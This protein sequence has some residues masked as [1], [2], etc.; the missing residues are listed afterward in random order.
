MNLPPTQLT[1][2]QYA[3]KIQDI[4]GREYTHDLIG[5]LQEVNRCP[6][7]VCDGSGLVNDPDWNEDTHTYI[8]TG[9]T[10]PCVCTLED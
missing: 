7:G 10:K 3:E 4:N 6:E 5:Y 9:S 8:E 1:P 2:K